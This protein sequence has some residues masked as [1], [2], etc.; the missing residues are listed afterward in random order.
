ME[1]IIDFNGFIIPDGVF[2]VKEICVIQVHNES[3]TY[4][5]YDCE[6]YVFRPPDKYINALIMRE[7]QDQD[8]NK[9]GILWDYGASPYEFFEQKLKAWVQNAR[10]FYV[11]GS[12]KH[13]FHSPDNVEDFA[14]VRCPIRE[15]YSKRRRFACAFQNAQQLK[16][17]FM[18]YWGV[19]PSYEKSVQIFYQLAD[20]RKMHPLDIACLDDHFILRFAKN[21]ICHVWHKLSI[22]L[23]NN[24][25]IMDYKFCVKHHK[26]GCVDWDISGI[27]IYPYQKDCYTFNSNK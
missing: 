11:L 18:D 4:N 9:Y 8:G 23:Q 1:Y 22:D 2:V 10:Y 12:Q 24:E 16:H 25:K 20:L 6:H 3:L 5:V 17:W 26:G 14:K 13:K 21:Q 15:F 27:Y 19:K 7:N